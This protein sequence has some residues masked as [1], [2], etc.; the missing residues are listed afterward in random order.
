MADSDGTVAFSEEQG[1]QLKMT[2]GTAAAGRGPGSILAAVEG[3]D[4]ARGNDTA[5]L[6]FIGVLRTSASAPGQ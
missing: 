3:T 5:L 6:P 1:S 4:D 2:G